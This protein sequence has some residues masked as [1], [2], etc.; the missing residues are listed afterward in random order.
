MSSLPLTVLDIEVTER[1]VAHNQ[2]YER[3]AAV[4]QVVALQLVL[5]KSAP[6]RH[7][8]YNGVYTAPKD[9]RH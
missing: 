1:T 3:N 9:E 5:L 2:R 4:T 8:K 6:K 7:G